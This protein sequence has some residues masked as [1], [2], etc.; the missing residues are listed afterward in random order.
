MNGVKERKFNQTVLIV[1]VEQV[2]IRSKDE[3]VA[4]NIVRK[5]K[6]MRLTGRH[7]KYAGRFD[8]VFI[9]IDYMKPGAFQQIQHF[10]KIM[11]V[12]VFYAEMT[13]SIKH[14]NLKLLAFPFR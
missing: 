10:E 8:R 4:F 1:S 12:R 13:I 7:K 3:N 2:K 5:F 6:F 14:F 11:P 9:A